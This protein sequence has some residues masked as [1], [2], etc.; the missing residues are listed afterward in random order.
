MINVNFVGRLGTDAEVRE[1]N[2]KQ[3]LHIR[4]AV[5]EYNFSTKERTTQ[6]IGVS[7]NSQNLVN[8]APH[9]KKGSSILVNGSG[10]LRTYLDKN[11]MTVPT[12]EVFADRIEFVNSPQKEQQTSQAAVATQNQQVQAAVTAARTSA[13]SIDAI[14]NRQASQVSTDELPF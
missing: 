10:K 14:V 11:S 4:V 13:P 9:L 6:W 7:S 8:L 2:G 12:M 1:Y 3:F 5:D